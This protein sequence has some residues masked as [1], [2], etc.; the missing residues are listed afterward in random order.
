MQLVLKT[1]RTHSIF[2]VVC[3]ILAGHA[4]LSQKPV[5]IIR[6]IGN[7]IPGAGSGQSGRP[8]AGS[9]GTDSLQTRNML[10]DSITVSIYYL[11]S[12]RGYKLDSTINDFTRRYPIPATHIYLGNTGTA[13]RSILFQ[14][15]LK[16]GWDPGFH[17]YDV[18]KWKLDKVKFYNTT[19]PYTELGYI[20]GA[21]GEQM[22]DIL[23]TQNIRPY[24]NFSL[25][26]RLINSPGVFRNQKT[27]HNN[28]LF[29]S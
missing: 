17:A 19:R 20:L 23:H 1:K 21:R 29:T 18:Y 7:K 13:T 22:I 27:N 5:E 4:G 16:A 26:Y 28:Y 14:P 8:A 24:W 3:L 10:E 15:D 2:F 11:D 6:G 12:P 25:G 9:G